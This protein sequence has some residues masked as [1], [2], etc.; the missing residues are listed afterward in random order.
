MQVKDIISELE[1]F[2]PLAYQESY[3]NSGLL[4]GETNM[5]LTGALCTLDVTEEIIDEALKYNCNL[6]ISHHP[7]IF[8]PLKK[9]TGKTPTEK[10]VLLA[11]KHNVAIFCGHTNFDNVYLGVNNKIAQKLNLIDLKILQPLSDNLVKLVTFVPCDHAERVRNSMFLAGAGHIGSYDSCSYNTEGYGTFRGSE[12][13]NPYVGKKGEMHTE[14]ETRIETIVPKPILGGVLNSMIK[15][16]PY[17][18]V[19]YDIYPITNTQANSGAGMIG[20]LEKEISG[21]QLLEKCKNVFHCKNISYTGNENKSIKNIAVCGG[22]GS[23]LIDKAARNADAFITGDIKYHQF[24]D[25]KKD[26]FLLDIGHF[27]SEQFT[28]EIFYDIIKEKFPTFAV[29]LSETRTNPVKHY[30]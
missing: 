17:E 27:E 16:H 20:I 8:S 13:T 5:E 30:S 26:L 29:R 15:F 11:I 4:I 19:A 24:L 6:I 3:D 10:I 23:F 7:V 12:D 1:C 28:P 14:K 2:A 9:L 22:S 25:A 21:A 18:E